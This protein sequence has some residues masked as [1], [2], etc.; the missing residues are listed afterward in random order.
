MIII[1]LERISPIFYFLNT[2]VISEIKDDLKQH[3]LKQHDL[4]LIPIFIA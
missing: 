4:L 1:R 2:H 3:D